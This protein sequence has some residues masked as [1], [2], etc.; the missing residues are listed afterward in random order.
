MQWIDQEEG[1]P[2]TE[3]ARFTEEDQTYATTHLGIK[4]NAVEEREVLGLNW[5]IMRDAFILRF[6]WLVSFAKELAST[7]RSI[8]RVVAKLY[9]PLGFMSPLFTAVKILFQDLCKSKTDWD[10]H[11]C[12]ELN[13]KYTKWLSDLTKVH[14]FSID[15]C[16]LL[17]VKDHV[18][19]LQIDG[20]GDSSETAYAATVYLRIETM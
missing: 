2:F 16:Y 18:T 15:R 10:E 19:S 9:H 7:K 11:L 12:D 3:S 4:G 8:L 14:S 6:D 20:F 13:F 17:N 1:V 5:H